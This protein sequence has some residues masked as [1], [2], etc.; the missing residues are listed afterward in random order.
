MRERGE[1]EGGEKERRREG[2][3][4]GW[5]TPTPMFQILKNTLFVTVFVRKLTGTHATLFA[6]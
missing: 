5:L 2:T 3:P 6:T 4:K 1:G